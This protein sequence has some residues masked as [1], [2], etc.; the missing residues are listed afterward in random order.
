MSAQ[1]SV[2]DNTFLLLEEI[3]W[4]IFHV[5]KWDGS[6][7]DKPVKWDKSGLEKKCGVRTVCYQSGNSGFQFLRESSRN[8]FNITWDGNLTSKPLERDRAGVEE[9]AG[10]KQSATWGKWRERLS[11]WELSTLRGLM[12]ATRFL[13][14]FSTYE[15]G[16]LLVQ[17]I[18]RLSPWQ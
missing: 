7:Q 18:K 13:Y 1:S 12:L 2:G 15:L 14:K 10:I 3:S 8:I 16:W 5:A 11:S 17:W 6:L 4:N 9:I